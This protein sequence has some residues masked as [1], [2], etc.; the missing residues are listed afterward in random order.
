VDV[1]V[2]VWQFQMVMLGAIYTIFWGQSQ[3]KKADISLSS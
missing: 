2:Q 1:A 3:I